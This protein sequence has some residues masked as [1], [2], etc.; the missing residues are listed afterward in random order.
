MRTD[1]IVSGQ[2]FVIRGR[3]ATRSATFFIFNIAFGDQRLPVDIVMTA[4]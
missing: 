2:Q 1:F 3:P 4:I